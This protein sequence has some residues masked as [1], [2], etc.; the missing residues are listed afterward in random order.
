MLRASLITVGD[1]EQLTGG[2]LYHRRIAAGRDDSDPLG[3]AAACAQG[4][5]ERLARADQATDPSIH[6]GIE[7]RLQAGAHRTV[8]DS[9]RDLVQHRH[10]R[11]PQTA[12]PRGDERGGDAVD[13]YDV[14]VSFRPLDDAMCSGDAERE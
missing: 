12:D 5:G 9:A 6:M 10:R 13:D 11:G 3:W 2:Y 14:D 7:P 1:P 4:V 8:I